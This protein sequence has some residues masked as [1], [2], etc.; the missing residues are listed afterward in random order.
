MCMIVRKR[1][2]GRRDII[3]GGT[4]DPEALKKRSLS[5][6]PGVLSTTRCDTQTR[7]NK[8]KNQGSNVQSHLER[9][10]LARDI[11]QGFRY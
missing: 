5:I 10:T 8:R 4:L 1:F 7:K 3:A 6:E 11:L 2:R 9:E